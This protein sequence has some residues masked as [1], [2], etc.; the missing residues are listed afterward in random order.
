MNEK[1]TGAFKWPLCN[2]FDV[3]KRVSS[4][5]NKIP[6]E[7]EKFCFFLTSHSATSSLAAVCFFI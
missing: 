3:K 2:V 4:R 7:S 5:V 6:S 1:K